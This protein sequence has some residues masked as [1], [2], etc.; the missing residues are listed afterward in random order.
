[1]LFQL[2]NNTKD[3]NILKL[4]KKLTAQHMWYCTNAWSF[5]IVI[6]FIA[7]LQSIVFL[8]G[9]IKMVNLVHS[10]STW[11]LYIVSMVS[12]IPGNCLPT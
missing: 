5:Y 2:S 12:T 8:A 3:F 1:M 6:V 7:N 4:N 9:Y 11:I 10:V